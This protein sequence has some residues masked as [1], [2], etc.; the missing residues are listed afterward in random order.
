V[1]EALLKSKEMS[2]RSVGDLVCLPRADLSAAGVLGC[3][4]VVFSTVGTVAA[5]DDDCFKG[6]DLEES[7]A[8]RGFCCCGCV[9]PAGDFGFVGCT[10]TLGCGWVTAMGQRG[11]MGNDWRLCE[12]HGGRQGRTQRW[13]RADAKGRKRGRGREDRATWQTT[14]TISSKISRMEVEK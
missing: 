6:V 3:A 7:V 12:Y 10:T 9:L 11:D 2:D 14:R 1:S 5:S 13:R 4:V 8:E